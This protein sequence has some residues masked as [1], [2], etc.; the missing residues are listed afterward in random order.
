MAKRATHPT[1][2]EDCYCLELSVLCRKY[3]LSFPRQFEAVMS[4]KCNGKQTGSINIA[5]NTYD[6]YIELDYNYN[7]Q[8]RKYRVP[9][10][11][12]ASNLG[13]GRVLYFVCPSTGRRCRKLYCVE[14]WFLHR[15]A[16]RD[17]C[18]Q[19]QTYSKLTRSLMAIMAFAKEDELMDKLHRCRKTYRGKPTRRYTNLMHRLERCSRRYEDEMREA[20]RL[21]RSRLM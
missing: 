11:S 8:P 1:I 2:I 5:V 13:I 10:V 9:L 21:H 15:T 7:G 3:D 6:M 19:Q 4:W 18:Y 16:F 20:E 14:G 17:C 12:T